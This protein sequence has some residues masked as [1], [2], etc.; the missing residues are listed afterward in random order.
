MPSM[1][2]G[3]TGVEVRAV[4]RLSYALNF[5]SKE[6][7]MQPCTAK[8]CSPDVMAMS[9]QFQNSSGYP[10]PSPHIPRPSWIQS[11]L[12]GAHSLGHDCWSNSAYPWCMQELPV[13]KWRREKGREAGGRA[14]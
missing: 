11:A 9:A 12:L 1:P 3:T 8:G 4:N 13:S 6:I 7:M 10:S 5:P 2:K 14:G